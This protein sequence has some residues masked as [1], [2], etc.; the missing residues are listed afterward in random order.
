MRNLNQI[1][2]TC[3]KG[4]GKPQKGE[5]EKKRNNRKVDCFDSNNQNVFFSFSRDFLGH[6][7]HGTREV[8]GVQI[9]SG[10]KKQNE[11]GTPVGSVR[12]T[13]VVMMIASLFTKIMH[14]SRKSTLLPSTQQQQKKNNLQSSSLIKL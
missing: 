10:A 12:H 7:L 3:Y 14:L 1:Q 6:T 2:S 9:A 8:W 13:Y 4:G 11:D 5:E